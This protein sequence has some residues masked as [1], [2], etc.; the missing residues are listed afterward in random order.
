MF[1][2]CIFKHLS[3]HN[4]KVF[5]ENCLFLRSF[6]D[7]WKRKKKKSYKSQIAMYILTRY[8]HTFSCAIMVFINQLVWNTFN[9]NKYHLR[10]NLMA[11]CHMCHNVTSCHTVTFLTYNLVFLELLPHSKITY[12]N[13]NPGRCWKSLCC[14]EAWYWYHYNLEW[15][16]EIASKK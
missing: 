13:L 5:S 15:F 4:I 7:N 16:P 12:R 2:Y 6:Y 11:D 8:W 10:Y 1:F 3:W 14:P 9:L